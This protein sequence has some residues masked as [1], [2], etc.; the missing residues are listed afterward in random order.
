MKRQTKV[1]GGGAGVVVAIAAIGGGAYYMN[2]TA[3][4]QVSHV[5]PSAPQLGSALASGTRLRAYS[6]DATASSASY[7]THETR[8]AGGGNAVVGTTSAVAGNLALDPAHPNTTRVGAIVVD[9]SQLQSDSSARD[10]AIRRAWLESATYPLATFKDIVLHGVPATWPARGAAS[11]TASG[12]LTIHATTRPVTWTMAATMRGTTVTIDATSPTMTMTEFN[13]QPP[14]NPVLHVANELT[15]RLHLV[16]RPS[17]GTFTAT[18][19]S[20]RRTIAVAAGAAGAS[21]GGFG[22]GSNGTVGRVA[23]LTAKTLTL[24]TFQGPTVLSTTA[25]TH[26]Y[27]VM[28]TASTALAV[29]QWV[30]ISASPLDPSTAASITISSQ[31][32]LF[33]QA[34]ASAGGGAPG[35]GAG[36]SQRPGAPGNGGAPGP[37]TGS[38]P[39][40]GGGSPPGNPPGAGSAPGGTPPRGAGGFGA[41]QA[42]NGRVTVARQG[43]LMVRTTRGTTKTIKATSATEVYTLVPETSGALAH[44]A[45]ATAQTSIIGGHQ[46]ATTVVDSGVSGP[47]ITI[48]SSLPTGSGV[49]AGPRG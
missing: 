3:P 38:P 27:R 16:A 20:P 18:P 5:A 39:G 24:D 17:T 10:N 32:N 37:G 40:S 14:D 46:V 35:T 22:A 30:S 45:L 31:G 47:M 4:V 21:G 9:I 42:I 48:S 33:V 7:D 1:I 23:A 15:L 6:I 49:G 29:G 25:H 19:S 43:M 26:Y 13:V 28:K 44:N 41:T 36:G 2:L 12:D 11:F 8:F 34:P